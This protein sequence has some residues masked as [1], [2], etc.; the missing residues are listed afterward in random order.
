VRSFATLLEE[1]ALVGKRILDCPSG[2]DAFVAEVHRRGLDVTGCDPFYGPAGF[3]ERSIRGDLSADA[4]LDT[5]PPAQNR[6]A[7]IRTYAAISM[8]A[9]A[10]QPRFHARRRFPKPHPPAMLWPMAFAIR[11]GG[12][13]GRQV[14][15]VEE[16]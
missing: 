1:K 6:S 10:G 13:H 14:P 8:R 15:E 9:C 2:P 12:P 16:A 3:A 4:S 11:N 7:G 5:R